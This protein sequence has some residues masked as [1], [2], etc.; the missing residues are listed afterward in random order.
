MNKFVV[1]LWSK[2]F[3]IFTIYVLHLRLNL[4]DLNSLLGLNLLKN[5][6][7]LQHILGGKKKTNNLVNALERA[8]VGI[9]KKKAC[10]FV[11]VKYI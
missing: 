1:T 3:L 7:K 6:Q 9:L 2:F 4:R 11:N 8:Q 10:L 5:E